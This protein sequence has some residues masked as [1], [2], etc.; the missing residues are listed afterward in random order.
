MRG[1]GQMPPVS[2]EIGGGCEVLRRI[3]QIPLALGVVLGHYGA[4][5]GPAERF[6]QHEADQYG[7]GLGHSW[8]WHFW[9]N[10]ACAC[11]AA[12]QRDGAGL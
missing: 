8:L 6:G 4:A 10:C 12:E 9:S 5:G 2:A 3:R 11:R 7:C 1:W